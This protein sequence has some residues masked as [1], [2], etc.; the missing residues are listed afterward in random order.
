ML[1]N[2]SATHAPGTLPNAMWSVLGILSHPR[3]G[4]NLIE[5][6]FIYLQINMLT[7][8]RVF[9]LI[10]ARFLEEKRKRFARLYCAQSNFTRAKFLLWITLWIKEAV[11]GY[12]TNSLDHF[13]T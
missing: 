5:F 12:D 6:Y 2:L 4:N 3:K 11:M 9:F 13:M 8:G 1:S 7:T 10:F